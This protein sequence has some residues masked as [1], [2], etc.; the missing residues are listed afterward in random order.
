MTSE[1]LRVATKLT[2]DFPVL[3]VASCGG[4]IVESTKAVNAL[5]LGFLY[6]ELESGLIVEGRK[7]VNALCG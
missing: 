5:N 7:V 1:G 3:P 4:L 2:S 6:E